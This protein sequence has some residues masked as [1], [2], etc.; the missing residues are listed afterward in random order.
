VLL[1]ILPL[2]IKFSTIL[3]SKA[4]EVS[5]NVVLN[6]FY[7]DELKVSNNNRNISLS[8]LFFFHRFSKPTFSFVDVV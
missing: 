3:I 1:L 6:A 4:E 8:Y 5:M 7:H 2:A